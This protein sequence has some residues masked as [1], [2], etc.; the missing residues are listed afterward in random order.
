MGGQRGRDVRLMAPASV[1]GRRLVGTQEKTSKTVFLPVLLRS[2]R[3][4]LPRPKDFGFFLTSYGK[5]YIRKGSGKRMRRWCDEAG[6]SHC[7]A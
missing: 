3:K 2:Q 7:S 5:P 1:R 6:L 4:A